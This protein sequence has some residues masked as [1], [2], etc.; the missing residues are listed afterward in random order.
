[1]ALGCAV[2]GFNRSKEG[3][4]LAVELLRKHYAKKSQRYVRAAL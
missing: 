1:V 4:E 2:L 3:F